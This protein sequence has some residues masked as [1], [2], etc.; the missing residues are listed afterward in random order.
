VDLD[1]VAPFGVGPIRRMRSLVASIWRFILFPFVVFI[2]NTFRGQKWVVDIAEVRRVI[3]IF[4]IVGRELI[5]RMIPIFF[6]F[7]I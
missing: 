4:F 7:I 5:L 6:K 3:P 2:R 1:R